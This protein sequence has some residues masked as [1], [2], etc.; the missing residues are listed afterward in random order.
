MQEY[1]F[2][3]RMPPDYTLGNEDTIAA[4][5][6]WF[7]TIGGDLIDRGKPAADAVTV[8]ACD[9]EGRLGGYSV[10]RAEAL[11][12]AIDFAEKCP[13]IAQGGGVEVARLVNLH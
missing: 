5:Q 1:V 2:V 4:W 9:T 10:I 11:S 13:V 3:Y 12:A 8:G 7:E 6:S